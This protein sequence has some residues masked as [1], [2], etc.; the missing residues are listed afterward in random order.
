MPPLGTARDSFGSNK[1]AKP[2]GTRPGG[3]KLRGSGTQLCSSRM[4][5]EIS[6]LVSQKLKG[7]AQH[8]GLMD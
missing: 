4:K 2:G 5:I 6:N 8:I 7:N 1:R 3:A